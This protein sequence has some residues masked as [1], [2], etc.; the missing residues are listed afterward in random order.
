MKYFAR[1]LSI[2]LH[3]LVIPLYIL[4]FIFNGDTL[5]AYIPVAAKQYCYIVTA[6]ALLVMPLL[7]LPVF[8][9]FK[10]IRDYELNSSHERVYPILVAVSF[11]FLGFWLLGRVPY[12]NIVQQLYLVL[13]V[14]LSVFSVITLRWKMSMHMTAIGGFCGFVLILAVKYPGDVKSIFMLLLLLSGFL[15]SSRLFLKKH[16]PLQVYAGFLFGLVF[17]CGILA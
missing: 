14:L 13:I 12:T 7:S 10:L 15:A 5:F 3:P 4:F 17:V 1:T 8:R 9:Y 16:T 6:F 2:V 11:A